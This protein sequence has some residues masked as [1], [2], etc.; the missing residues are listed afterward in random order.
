MDY[1]T[2]SILKYWFDKVDNWQKDLFIN[3]WKGKS[4][5]EVCKRA[6][7]LAYKEYNV[8]TCTLVADTT[9][10]SDIEKQADHSS[11]TTLLSISNIQG[12]SALKP[13]KPLSFV[14]GLNVVY[15]GNGCGK[16][17]YV[18]VLKK[19]ENPKKE[20]KI[21]PNV[22]EDSP[23]PAKATLEFSEDG[24]KSNINW[25][26]SSNKVCPIRIYD[27][28]VARR[29]VTDSTEIIYEPKLLNVFSLMADIYDSIAAEIRDEMSCTESQIK[30]VPY[31]LQKTDLF[32]AYE[33]IKKQSDIQEFAKTIYFSKEDENK[34][35]LIEKSF[36]DQNPAATREKLKAQIDIIK[37]IKKQLDTAFVG[38]DDSKIL[39][40]Q[41]ARNKQIETR[42]VYEDFIKEIRNISAI[43]GFG[44]DKW[45]DLWKASKLYRES[46]EN[47]YDDLCVLCQ[48][49]LSPDTKERLKKFQAVYTSELEANQQ[50]AQDEYS[51]KL[52]SIQELISKNLNI[53]DIKVK[54]T[55]NTFD[56]EIISFFE[57]VASGLLN[58]A[59][60]IYNY[61]TDVEKTCPSII[62]VDIFNDRINDIITK[63]ESEISSLNDVIDNFEEQSKKRLEM[64]AKK[65]FFDND[66]NLS[67]LSDVL[68]FKE[69]LPKFKTNTLT[70]TKNQL[71][72]KLITEVYV[73]RFNKELKMLNP[74]GSIRVELVSNGK[75][76]KTSHHVS[77]KDAIDGSM[78][79]K[80][81]EDI[82][83]EGE[84]RV[85]SIAAF[86]ADLNSMNK[87]QAFIFD[88]PIT[89][90]DHV[91]E[92]N[93]ARLLVDLSFERQVI[94]FTH[95]LAFAETLKRC[96]DEAIEECS[97]KNGSFNYI[98]LLK[99]PLGEPIIMGGYNRLDF[100]S[101]LKVIKGQDIPQYK[102]LFDS[103][104]YDLAESK[105]KSICSRM[106]INVE[107]G[108]EKVLLNGLVNRYNMNISSQKIRYLNAVEETDVKLFDDMMTK[109]SFFEHPA[110][111]EKPIEYPETDEILND[112]EKL[113]NWHQ[114]FKRKLSKC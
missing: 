99:N 60:W 66:D 1:E 74:T 50:K 38:L 89:S 40:I 84:A 51:E 52:Q 85:V 55:T 78:D 87:T 73:E 13:T 86:L 25:S 103:G 12:V 19:A 111:S 56:G 35:T 104:E 82:L 16:S 2:I 5:D 30:T 108:I 45:K 23:V 102:R 10:P 24:V 22:F 63:I 47:T 43:E 18:R 96:M 39:D 98:E 113:L 94:V 93:V 21:Y 100:D 72:E 77:I 15:G 109:Y 90:L 101:V 28:E 114:D 64:L 107:R 26:L 105:M 61:G 75:K 95:R 79:K 46:L 62:K 81:T 106:R 49:K 31:E 42:K 58:K 59:N 36:S 68:K 48:Q 20:V 3:L 7:K 17:S 57:T 6:K 67:F 65:W 71:S 91:Y 34:L 9:F 14:E 4:A 11:S 88:D 112:V 97:S 33:N 70:K 37:S 80:N 83:S 110:S 29:F 53:S 32:K 54:L 44:G 69:V 92:D 41:N 76:G 27:S 8:E